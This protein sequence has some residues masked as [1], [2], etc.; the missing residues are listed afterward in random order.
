MK[1]VFLLVDKVVDMKLKQDKM[2]T[3]EYGTV[4]LDIFNRL[5]KHFL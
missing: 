4:N 5:R 2:Q 3:T 1:Y